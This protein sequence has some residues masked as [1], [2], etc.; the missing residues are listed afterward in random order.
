MRLPSLSDGRDRTHS[1][2]YPS[3]P[4]LPQLPLVNSYSRDYS[5][6]DIKATKIHFSEKTPVHVRVFFF[7]ADIGSKNGILIIEGRILRA[8]FW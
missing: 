8:C 1:Q 7:V 2:R 4:R 3:H 5:A 6:A